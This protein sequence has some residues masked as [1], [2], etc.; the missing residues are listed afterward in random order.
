M[1]ST[2]SIEIDSDVLERLRARHPGKSDRELIED[3]VLIELG[4]ATLSD[5]QRRFALPEQEAISLGV[6]AVHEARRASL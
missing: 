2:R 3:L 5:V 1:A 4:R 6:R